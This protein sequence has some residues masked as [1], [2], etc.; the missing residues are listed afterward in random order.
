MINTRQSN[1]WKIIPEDFDISLKGNKITLKS[2]SKYIRCSCYRKWKQKPEFKSWMRLYV[3]HI[4]L[5][6][7]GKVCIQPFSFQL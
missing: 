3:F 4:V 6:L 5:M 7:L 2:K 1:Y